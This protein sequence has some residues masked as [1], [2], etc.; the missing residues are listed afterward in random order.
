MNKRT[1]ISIL[2]ITLVLVF[3]IGALVTASHVSAVTSPHAS[4]PPGEILTLT[5]KPAQ[6][7]QFTQWARLGDKNGQLSRYEQENEQH[8]VLNEIDDIQKFLNEYDRAGLEVN[9]VY[10]EETVR[11]VHRYQANPNRYPYIISPWSSS[12]STRTTGNWK[13][14]TRY[15]ANF[16][17]G[18]VDSPVFLEDVNV[19]H[20]PF[21]GTSKAPLFDES[22]DHQSAWQ[23]VPD[24]TS[25][26]TSSHERTVRLVRRGSSPRGSHDSHSNIQSDT[27][28]PTVTID[29]TILQVDP[30]HVDNADFIVVFSEPINPATFTAADI[31]VSGTTGTITTGP[32]DTGNMM[33]FTFSVTGMTDLDTVVVTI[34]SGGI[35]DLAGNTNI[36]STSTDNQ[37]MYEEILIS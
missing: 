11:A 18:C 34:P 2:S 26:D 12:Y 35:E 33:V 24:T 21:D 4:C 30:T 7:P 3:V 23:C 16:E 31:T 27:V 25:V 1:L 5:N 37:V 22:A 13:N 14:T 15:F 8:V 29:Q 36:S 19:P 10:D 9:G 20:N 28:S 17:V 6:C 32:I